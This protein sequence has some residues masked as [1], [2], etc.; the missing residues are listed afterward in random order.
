MT[1]RMATP[2][3]RALARHN[4]AP[5]PITR[6]NK[7]RGAQAELNL[8]TPRKYRDTCTNASASLVSVDKPL[9][10]KQKNFVKFWA[11]G[12]SIPNATL[13]AG[14][15]GDGVGYRLKEQPNVLAL[16]RAEKAKYEEAAQMT[17]KK[18]MDGLQEAIDMAKLM[19]EPASMISGW[20]EIGKMCGY[21]APVEHKV[22]VDVT[23]NIVLN[24]LNSLSDAELLKIITEGAKNGSTALAPELGGAGVGEAED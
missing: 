24:K 11:Q 12:D 18:V 14:F 6:A 7:K 3:P 19:S 8:A 4:T 5:V 20:R 16:Y 21:Y 17:R 1:A 10:E 13:R 22:K 2:S 23:G 9:T 15:S